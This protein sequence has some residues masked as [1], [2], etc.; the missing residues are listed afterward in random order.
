M[1]NALASELRKTED[2]VPTFEHGERVLT[3][4]SSLLQS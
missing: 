2:E 3:A 1:V 4:V